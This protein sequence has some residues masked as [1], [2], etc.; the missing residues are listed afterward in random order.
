MLLLG[1]DAALRRSELVALTLGDVEPIPGRGLRVLVRRFNTDQQGQGQEIAVW[2]N[3]TE[4]GFCPLAALD[5][6]LMHR[7]TA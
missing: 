4:A 3:P 2:A 1:F 6:W 5:A 7:R